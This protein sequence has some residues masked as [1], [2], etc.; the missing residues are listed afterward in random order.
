MPPDREF[1]GQDRF[2]FVAGEFV[3]TGFDYL[4]EPTPYNADSTNLLNYSDP[5]ERA[6]AEAELKALGKIKVPSRSS[7]FGI[8][9]LAGFPKDRFYLYQSRWRSDLAMAHILPH[10]NWPERVGQVTPVHVYTSGDE[11]ELFLNGKSLGR[12]KKGEFQYRLRWDDVVYEPGELKVV[13]YKDGQPWA[14]EIVRTTGTASKISLE[15]DRSR[16]TNDGRDLSFVTVRVADAQGR[17]VPRTKNALAFSIS[18]PG[19]IVA[20]DNGDATDLTA[21]KSKSRKAYNGMALVI[22]RAKKGKSG[23][24]ALRATSPGLA[25]SQI[26]L[27]TNK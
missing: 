13:A 26:A 15:A 11:A 24:I 4:G 6:K 17:T 10:W 20:T 22:V 14:Q 9:D 23:Q 3:W 16:I 27:S 8:V 18:G 25:P 21:F 1:E 7:Y 5:A 2:P 12:K 19:E